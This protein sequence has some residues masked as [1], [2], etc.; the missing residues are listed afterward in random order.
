MFYTSF[1]M[2]SE[3]IR[4]LRIEAGLSQQAL[5]DRLGVPQSNVARLESPGYTGHSVNTL[6][7]VAK[8]LDAELRLELSR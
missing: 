3:Q 6:R 5:A 2:I 1:K 4:Q 8:A 7:R